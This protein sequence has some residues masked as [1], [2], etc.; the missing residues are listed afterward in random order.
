MIKYPDEFMNSISNLIKAGYPICI[1]EEPRLFVN[2]YYLE[3]RKKLG[4]L[5]KTLVK[6]KYAIVTGSDGLVGSESV[7]Y[8]SNLGFKVIGIDNNSRK[9]FLVKMLQL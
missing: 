9:K 1:D 6:E 7:K 3:L 8:F 4:K 2:Y 5:K